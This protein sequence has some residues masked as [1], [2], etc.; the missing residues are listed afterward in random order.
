[1]LKQLAVACVAMAIF[2]L[3]IGLPLSW[4]F[5]NFRHAS[6]TNLSLN[7]DN[8]SGSQGNTVYIYR[9]SVDY[10][11][12]ITDPI[13]IFTFILCA[14]T[15]ALALFTFG[16]FAETTRL[17]NQSERASRKA[18]EA[19]TKA[20]QTLVGMERAYLTGGGDIEYRGGRRC[21]RVEV[22]N[23]GKTAAYLSGFY[24]RF[25]TRDEL[26]S[27]SRPTAFHRHIYDDRIPPGGMT[28]VLQFIPIDHPDPEFIYGGFC[29][30]DLQKGRHTFRFILRIQQ[31]GH[32]RPDVTR[33]SARL[34]KW[35]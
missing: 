11:D 27:G 1:M 28:R 20:T 25:A 15:G 16:L 32:T 14:V 26:E 33:V 8:N 34:R 31:N 35:T 13:S 4:S 6:P 24:V 29:Y 21:F 19:S 3:A 7:Q 22:A 9:D 30:R 23:Y 17:A 2:G 10:L 18:L 5:S 12:K